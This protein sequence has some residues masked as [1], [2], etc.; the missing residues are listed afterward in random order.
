[1]Y[2]YE[3]FCEPV[4][5]P[6]PEDAPL[7]DKVA[8][9]E[10]EVAALTARLDNLQSDFKSFDHD[11]WFRTHISRLADEAAKEFAQKREIES[12]LAALEKAGV[13]ERIQQAVEEMFHREANELGQGIFNALVAKIQPYA[14]KQR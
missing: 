3:D 5:E 2:R 6:L 12:L 8:A 11:E 4:A 14:L 13:H 1:M 10:K 9:L 7:K